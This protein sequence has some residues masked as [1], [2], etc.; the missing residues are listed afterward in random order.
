LLGGATAAALGIVVTA[1]LASTLTTSIG[2]MVM[3][4]AL[5]ITLANL[6]KT[7]AGQEHTEA[8]QPT[9]GIKPSFEIP[10]FTNSERNSSDSRRNKMVEGLDLADPKI[11]KPPVNNAP[12]KKPG[13][14]VGSEKKG[15]KRNS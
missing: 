8:V 7:K 3:G 15:P 1:G 6:F 4:S 10:P 13:E 11:F 14:A 2:A 5:F 12:S 9:R